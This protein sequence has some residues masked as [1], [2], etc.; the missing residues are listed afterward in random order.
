MQRLTANKRQTG[1]NY[2]KEYIALR[3]RRRMTFEPDHECQRIVK[4]SSGA[5]PP[6]SRTL[7]A[8]P[9]LTATSTCWW[10]AVEVK[11]EKQLEVRALHERTVPDVIVTRPEDFLWRKDVLGQWSGKLSGK[12]NSCISKQRKIGSGRSGSRSMNS[13]FD[14]AV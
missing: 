6:L 3:R 1:S 9:I 11:R 2:Q 4:H 13:H 10:Y 7:A 8:M 5:D 14:I 12:E